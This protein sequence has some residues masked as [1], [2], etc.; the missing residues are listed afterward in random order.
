MAG[1]EELD[2]LLAQLVNVDEQEDEAAGVK[3]SSTTTTKKKK[4][5]KSSSG[6]RKKKGEEDEAEEEGEE[7][8]KEK[9]KQKER[10]KEEDLILDFSA[11]DID[12]LVSMFSG[13]NA[14]KEGQSPT[15]LF[16]VGMSDEMGD[17]EDVAESMFE[18]DE[19]DEER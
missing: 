17:L 1:E 13:V 3:A 16:D 14:N 2:L 8:E 10:E 7:E 19:D 12:E 5:K 6:S 4:T 15:D 9:G 11:A 18:D